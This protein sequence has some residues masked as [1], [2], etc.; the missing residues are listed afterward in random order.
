MFLRNVGNLPDI[1]VL[2]I[3]HFGSIVF[4][5]SVV[6]ISTSYGLDDTGVGV[7]VPVG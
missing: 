2:R 4:I 7:R 1:F 3:S 5:Y 6:G